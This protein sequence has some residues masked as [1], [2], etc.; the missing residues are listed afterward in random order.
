LRTSPVGDVDETIITFTPDPLIFSDTR[1]GADRIE[2]QWR[3]M[4]CMV[5]GFTL[6]LTDERGGGA[7]RVTRSPGGVADLARDL[8]ALSSPLFDAPIVLAADA[9]LSDGRSMHVDLA[10][11]WRHSRE[12]TVA[13]A[14]NGWRSLDE[15]GT[16]VAGLRDALPDCLAAYAVE[17]G[18]LA[19]R[20][21]RRQL[22][23][24]LRAHPAEARAIVLRAGA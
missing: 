2:R 16:Q 12:T 15:A 21:A 4:S 17:A 23:A 22:F 19:R 20:A 7:T 13:S 9:P 8:D 6:A 3:A 18:L 1:F 14:V 11:R 24:W 10:L 5:P